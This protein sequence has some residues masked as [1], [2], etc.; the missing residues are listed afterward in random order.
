VEALSSLMS[1]CKYHSGYVTNV[2]T[3]LLY[4]EVI[5]VIVNK[6][7][8]VRS[9]QVVEPNSGSSTGSQM[10]VQGNI[11]CTNVKRAE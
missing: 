10:R 9:T 2:F 4:D 1:K 7:G 11:H 6:M 3:L 5:A 8:T